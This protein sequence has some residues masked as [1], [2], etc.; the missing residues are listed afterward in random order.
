MWDFFADAR[1]PIDFARQDFW[2]EVLT[3]TVDEFRM[4][5]RAQMA[6]TKRVPRTSEW[7]A[8]FLTNY[9]PERVHNAH[10]KLQRSFNP[11]ISTRSKLK[12]ENST[13]I[14]CFDEARFLCDTSALTGVSIIPPRHGKSHE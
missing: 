14:I 8:A 5:R 13:L 2:T 7:A 6:K 11:G 4:L 3:A 12:Q 10:E 9:Y 1:E